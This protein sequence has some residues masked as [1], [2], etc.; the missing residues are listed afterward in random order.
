VSRQ[1]R[2]KSAKPRYPPTLF[3]STSGRD[4]VDTIRTAV[5][6]AL[7]A[8]FAGVRTPYAAERLVEPEAFVVKDGVIQHRN[9]WAAYE[10]GER[11]PHPKLRARAGQVVPGSQWIF[12]HVVWEAPRT[13]RRLGERLEPLLRKL[14]PGVQTILFDSPGL[15]GLRRRAITAQSL[16]R[17][18]EMAGF[19]SL[20]CLTLLVREAHELGDADQAH[21][22]AHSLFKVLVI[23]CMDCRLGRVIRRWFAIYRDRIFPLA[24]A[25]GKSFRLEEY[26]IVEVINE[27]SR[28]FV[29]AEDLGDPSALRGETHFMLRAF[30]RRL[31]PR[32]AMVL[33]SPIG[34]IDPAASPEMQRQHEAR[35]RYR[36][37]AI[38]A[39]RSGSPRMFPPASVLL[40]TGTDKDNFTDAQTNA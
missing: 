21:R 24:T 30:R 36:R 13:E 18:E 38:D 12:D 4:D 6:Y 7:F 17:L 26:D 1:D 20:A 35:L 28:I 15:R 9:K 40:G 29:V 19:D 5:W 16:K 10:R 31:T 3:P 11:T 27:F 33:M 14:E 22:I 37:W 25:R 8:D 34:P 2:K 23:V 32:A 39:I